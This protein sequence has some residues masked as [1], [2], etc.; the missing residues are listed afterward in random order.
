MWGYGGLVGM[1]T[2]EATDG[3]DEAGVCRRGI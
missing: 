3:A 1:E 2:V